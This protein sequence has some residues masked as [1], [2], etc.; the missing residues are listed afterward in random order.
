MMILHR[1]TGSLAPAKQGHPPGGKLTPHGEWIEARVAADGEVTLDELCVELAGRGVDVH[2]ST[3]GRF[4]NQLGPSHKSLKASEQFRPEIAHARDL[5]IKRLRRFFNKAL[6]RL[7]FIDGEAVVTAPR[8]NAVERPCAQVSC[9]RDDHI[10]SMRM[11]GR[12]KWQTSTGYGK[13]A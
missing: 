6:A 4:L 12:L 8:S 7:I 1:A 2:H 11:D 5:W 3:V 9:Q 13:R 10:A